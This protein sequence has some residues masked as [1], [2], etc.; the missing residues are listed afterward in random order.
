MGGF[1]NNK[2]IV[3]DGLTF[4]V[5]AANSLS[6]SGTGTA[7]NDLI[8]SNDGTIN[9]ATYDSANG[10][11]IVFDGND[12]VNTN[13]NP[14]GLS[15]ITFCIWFKTSMTSRATLMGAYSGQDN[16]NTNAFAVELNRG[17]SLSQQDGLFYFA[18]IG[19]GNSNSQ[20]SY[21][22]NTSL[23]DGD[24]H[25]LAVTHDLPTG[26]VTMTLDDTNRSV[27]NGVTSSSGPWGVFQYDPHIGANN[28]QGNANTYFDGELASVAI[29]DRVLS[30]SE[31]AQNYNALK[32]RFL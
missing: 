1:A 20:T 2:K 13:Y 19:A 30:A 12:R 17:S 15:A 11:H 18:R 32:N 8:G 16:T 25:F 7:W 10:G 22:T 3:Q 14:E 6:H 4:Y 9:G 26:T 5:D 24:W 31:I 21:A 23:S 27:S 28:S 29:Y